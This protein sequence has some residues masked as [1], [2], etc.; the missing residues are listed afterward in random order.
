MVCHWNWNVLY[1]CGKFVLRP[2]TEYRKEY[3]ETILADIDEEEG[4]ITMELL[5]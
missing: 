5:I 2:Q 3:D 1:I 4:F